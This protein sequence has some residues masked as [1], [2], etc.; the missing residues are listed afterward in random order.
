M[1]FLAQ[2]YTSGI[3]VNDELGSIPGTLRLSQIGLEGG[4]RTPTPAIVVSFR[5]FSTGCQ[6]AEL[7]TA[8]IA[9][10][11]LQQG[12]GMHG[13]FSRADTWNFMAASGPDFRKAYK[14]PY[15]SATP[16]SVSPSPIS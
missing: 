1:R 11:V 15:L 14:D 3:F 5:S 9:D 2:D 13:S 12:Q 8:E 16:I 6:R 4:A 10:T 7:C